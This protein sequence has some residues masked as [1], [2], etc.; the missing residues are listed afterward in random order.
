M[1]VVLDRYAFSGFAYSVA[2][3]LGREWCNSPDRGLPAPDVIFYLSLP[4]EEA[5]KRGQFGNERYEREEFQRKVKTIFDVT[6]GTFWKPIDV[7]HRS[8]DD[9]QSQLR[10]LAIDTIEASK[11]AKIATLCID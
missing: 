6:V 11:H 4:V 1:T 3:G 10:A 8:V 7:T 9:I 2:K 5:M